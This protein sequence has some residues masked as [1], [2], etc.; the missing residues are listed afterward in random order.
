MG[1]KISELTE[2]E[3]ASNSDV[4]PIVDSISNGTQKMKLAALLNLIFPIGSRYTTQT[5]TNPNT[6]LG[7][8]TWERL[9]G[10][11]CVGLDEEDEAFN[12]IGKTGGE[13]TH[14]L[15]ISE[16]PSHN[17]AW[18][19]RNSAQSGST[20]WNSAG[21]DSTGSASDPIGNTGGNQPHNNLQPYEVVGYEW[22]RRK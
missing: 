10:R 9:K 1:V 17:H 21:S 8:G 13:K 12:K 6:I 18:K 2:K 19:Y 11:V 7:F 3:T 16:M 22:I 15:T 14:T 4:I 5:N 20:T